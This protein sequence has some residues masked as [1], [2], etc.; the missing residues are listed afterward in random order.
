MGTAVHRQFS[1]YLGW[2]EAGCGSRVSKVYAKIANK[3]VPPASFLVKYRLRTTSTCQP[4]FIQQ[5]ASDILGRM[6]PINITGD[7]LV[8]FVRPSKWYKDDTTQMS[9]IYYYDIVTGAP[10]AYFTSVILDAEMFCP[11]IE[12]NLSYVGIFS[13]V[14]EKEK[15]MFLSFFETSDARND[16][17]TIYVCQEHYFAVMSL[18]NACLCLKFMEANFFAALIMYTVELQWLEH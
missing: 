1:Q 9:Q 8:V 18:T 6:I 16:S 10:P 2:E 13:A 17:D 14:Q 5:Q 7:I 4:D 15:H 3:T 12:L 11:K